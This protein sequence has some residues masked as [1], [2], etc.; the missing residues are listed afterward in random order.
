MYCRENNNSA[1]PSQ[2]GLSQL[3]FFAIFN[4][5]LTFIILRKLVKNVERHHYRHF[6][7]LLQ[8]QRS[9]GNKSRLANKSLISNLYFKPLYVPIEANSGSIDCIAGTE[10]SIIDDSTERHLSFSLK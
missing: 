1:H 2:C 10:S 9:N 6:S 4:Y 7:N 3:T 8:C 5:L